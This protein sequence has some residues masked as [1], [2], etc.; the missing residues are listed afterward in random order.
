MAPRRG[1]SR[2]ITTVDVSFPGDSGARVDSVQRDGQ[3]ATRCD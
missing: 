2:K 1:H 3:I